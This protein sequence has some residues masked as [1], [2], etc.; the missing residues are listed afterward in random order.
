[1]RSLR[2]KLIGISSLILFTIL[3]VTN[4]YG[5][6]PSGCSEQNYI[7]RT[8]SRY[9][10]IYIAKKKDTLTSI[11]KLHCTTIEDLLELNEIKNPDLIQIGQEITIPKRKSSYQK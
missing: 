8:S 6:Q 1:M 3:S 10:L 5:N 7:S 4:L 9:N 2:S 11:A